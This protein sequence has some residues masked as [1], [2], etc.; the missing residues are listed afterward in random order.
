MTPTRRRCSACLRRNAPP[1]DP[2]APLG[3]G[4]RLRAEGRKVGAGVPVIDRHI[5][6]P[7]R[8]AGSGPSTPCFSDPRPR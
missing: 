6:G 2:R 3:V 8:G 4:S 1:P 5:Y 7:F